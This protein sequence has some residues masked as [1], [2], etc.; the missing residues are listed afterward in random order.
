MFSNVVGKFSTQLTNFDD[1]ITFLK[2][3]KDQC[4]Q[5][6]EA[7]LKDCL[8]VQRPDLLTHALTILAPMGWERKDDAFFGYS[9]IDAISFRFRTPQ[10]HAKVDCSVLQQEWDDMVDYTKRY[11]YLNLVQEDYSVLWWKLFNSLTAKCIYILK[12]NSR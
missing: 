9:A 5:A 2:K 3:T 7:C 1:C 12:F 6:I 10:E 4:V 8:K 11:M